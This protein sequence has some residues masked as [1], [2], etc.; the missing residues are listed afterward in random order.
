MEEEV[1][2]RPLHRLSTEVYGEAVKTI[3]ISI[4]MLTLCGIG[5]KSLC[6]E[7]TYGSGSRSRC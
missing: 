1:R 4:N 5:G 2:C 3:F 6:Q 7:V